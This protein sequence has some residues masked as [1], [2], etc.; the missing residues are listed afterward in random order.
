MPSPTADLEARAN[1]ETQRLDAIIADL[2]AIARHLRD[3][4]LPPDMARRLLKAVE[5]E[6]AP[7][8]KAREAL[9]Q[10]RV[11]VR[12]TRGNNWHTEADG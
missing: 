2:T 9:Q 12:D 7:L 5:A 3:G 4:H 8:Y 1:R 10:Y 11:T 6:R